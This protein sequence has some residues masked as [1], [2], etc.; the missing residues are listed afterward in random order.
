MGFLKRLL[1]L[2]TR[3]G[4]PEAL[5]DEAFEATV[6]GPELPVFVFFFNLWCSSCQVMH[7][8]LNEVGP[9]Y[10]GRARFYKMDATK[11]P[12][13]VT[14]MEIRGVPVLAAFSPDG[15]TDR[16]TG[17]MDITELRNWIEDHLSPDEQ[18]PGRDE[19]ASVRDEE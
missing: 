13:A 18:N 9:E 5:H 11:S 4:E 14:A 17:L 6:T 2:E 12:R 16:M 15:K 19:A 8:L 10:T 7:G 3:P 1:G